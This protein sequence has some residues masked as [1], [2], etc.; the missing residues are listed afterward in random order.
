MKP[1]S[2]QQRKIQFRLFSLIIAITL[3]LLPLSGLIFEVHAS[4]PTPPTRATF[5]AQF[6]MDAG[7]VPM[8]LLVPATAQVGDQVTFVLVGTNLQSLAGFQV[9]VHFD[10]AGLQFANASVSKEFSQSGGSPVTVGPVAVDGAVLLAAASC[11]VGDCRTTRYAEAARQAPRLSGTLPLAI[12]T[13]IVRS[14]GALNLQVV[15]AQL[16]DYSGRLLFA[17]QQVSQAAT[18]STV[19]LKAMDVTGNHFINDSDASTVIGEWINQF[20]ASQCIGAVYASYD[21]DGSGCLDIADVQM[22]LAHWGENTSDL[23]LVAPQSVDGPAAEKTLIVNSANDTP[24]ADST[25]GE[26]LDGTGECTLRAAIQESNV[27][28]GRETITFNIFNPGGSCPNLVTINPSTTLEI[29]DPYNLGVTIDGYSQCNA[30]ANTQL[31]NGNAVIKIEIKGTKTED[32][33]GLHIHSGNNTIKGLALYDWNHQI[34]L[35]GARSNVN[36]IQGN[37]IGTNAANTLLTRFAGDDDADGIHFAWGGTYNL[38]GGTQPADR[39]II[40]GAPQDGIGIR[41]AESNH[42]TIIGNY[43]GITQSGSSAYSNG[44]DGIDFGANTA[45]NTVGG[46]NPGERNVISGNY[47]DGV[48]LGHQLGTNRNEIVGNFIGVNP[49]GTEAKGN[50]GKGITVEDMAGKNSFHRNVVVGNGTYGMNLWAVDE[51]MIYEN[52]FGVLPQGLTPMDVIP[53]P[54]SVPEANLIALPNGTKNNPELGLSGIYIFGGSQK[55]V[56]QRNIIA[57]HLQYGVF[58]DADDGWTGGTCDPYF[59]TISEN[60]IYHNGDLG[61]YFRPDNCGADPTIYHPN[62]DSQPPVLVDAS[63]TT[64]SGTACNNCTVELF[65]TDKTQLPDP[66]DN[67]G[68]GKLLVGKGQANANGQF[69]IGVSGLVVGDIVSGTSTDSSGNTSQFAVNVLVHLAVPTDVPTS[70]TVPTPVPTGTPV[71]T[72]VPLRGTI[73]LPIVTNK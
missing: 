8:E 12:F 11:P 48:E 63:T 16:V 40:S 26:C 53:V 25:D 46:L 55:N 49:A 36:T 37:F 19:A 54:F 56:I 69:S 9:V 51:E 35:S 2:T 41:G 20:E 3:I 4:G 15:Q 29:D 39:N 24:D 5:T 21:L 64:I 73:Y 18:A 6:E 34:Y 57:N 27:R 60:R 72:D 22:I 44:S 32:V 17:S 31:V 1:L 65:L 71:P 45:D 7:P 33:N 66:F 52:F 50:N 28:Y 68:E 62:Q 42:N 47:G 30:S 70:T 23:A 43:I 61:I 38:I 13:F 10:P 59:N 14:P 67:S 58:L